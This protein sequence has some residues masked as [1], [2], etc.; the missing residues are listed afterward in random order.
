MLTILGKDQCRNLDRIYGVNTF[1]ILMAACRT[2]WF[3][4]YFEN[5][6]WDLKKYTLVPPQAAPYPAG[7]HFCRPGY[8][9]LRKEFLPYLGLYKVRQKCPGLPARRLAG[10]RLIIA[11]RATLT[12]KP[13]NKQIPMAATATLTADAI[14][15][16]INSRH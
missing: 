5:G 4:R 15:F 6:N 1:R 14:I 13:S 8:S 7:C 9:S 2:L 11:K 10:S 16:T 12:L 3:V